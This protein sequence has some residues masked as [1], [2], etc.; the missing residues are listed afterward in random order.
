MQWIVLGLNFPQR[1][2]SSR[3]WPQLGGRGLRFGAV[4]GLQ[5]RP[6]GHQL[7]REDRSFPGRGPIGGSRGLVRPQEM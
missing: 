6:A 1:D 3:V 7:H 2:R 5:R 4:K